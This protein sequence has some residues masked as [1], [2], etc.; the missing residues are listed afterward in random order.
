[1]ALVVEYS[2]RQFFF[3]PP[4]HPSPSSQRHRNPSV[5][6]RMLT[7]PSVQSGPSSIRDLRSDCISAAR[8]RRHVPSPARRL[9]SERRRRAPDARRVGPGEPSRRPNRTTPATTSTSTTAVATPTKKRKC[10]PHARG[11]LHAVPNDEPHHPRHHVRLH[12]RHH[13][14]DR[15]HQLHTSRKRHLARRPAKQT[16]PPQPP[17]PAPCQPQPRRQEAQTALSTQAATCMPSQTTNRTTPATTS[18]CTSATATPTRSTNCTP[19]AS[20]NMHAV[21][22]VEPHHPRHRHADKKHKL[23]AP[24]KRQHARRPKRRTAPPAPPPRRQE[25]P[26]ARLTQ[27]ATCT[28]SHMSNRTTPATAT[29]TRTTSCTPHASGNMHAVPHDKPHHPRHRLQLVDRRSFRHHH[30]DKVHQLH[31]PRQVQLA[32]CPTRHAAPPP[33]PRPAPRSPQRRR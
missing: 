25:P 9:H 31:T 23:P 17:R 20:G 21:P 22:H 29:P 30:A 10:T 1:M 7:R 4:L 12:V 32:H 18:G 3:Q 5:Q 13:H 33:P 28:P 16:A 19:H 8:C 27:A 11:N 24:R 6:Q 2:P 14:A 15:K 26:A